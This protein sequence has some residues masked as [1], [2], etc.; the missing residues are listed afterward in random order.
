MRTTHIA[1]GNSSA[2]NSRRNFLRLG[3]K[4]ILL[5]GLMA[6]SGTSAFGQGARQRGEVELPKTFELVR[7]KF[8]PH[9]N[10]YFTARINGEDLHFQLIEVNDLKWD[11]I[12]KSAQRKIY[13]EA[14]RQKAREESFTLVFR[15]AT[16]IEL[17]Q[18]TYQLKHDT[19]GTVE[20][21][22]VPVEKKAGPWQLFEAVFNRLQ[23]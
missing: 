18:N 17:R 8:S 2:P 3:M 5:A 23:Q 22:L 12:T 6:G 4:G 11:S 21:F 20:L 15:I 10:D 16:E 19:L 7:S 1:V 9:L 13:E 14:F